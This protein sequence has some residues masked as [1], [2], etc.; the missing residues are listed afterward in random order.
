VA[1]GFYSQ[2][3]ARVSYLRVG[4]PPPEPRLHKVKRY[5]RVGAVVFGVFVLGM[6]VAYLLTLLP[7]N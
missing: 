7:S 1:W 2:G 4:G 3:V 5:A 6:W